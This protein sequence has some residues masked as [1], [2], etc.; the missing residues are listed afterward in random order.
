MMQRAS[1]MTQ[2]SACSFSVLRANGVL[3]RANLLKREQLKKNP[4]I[5]LLPSN[6]RLAQANLLIFKAALIGCESRYFL[7]PRKAKP[8]ASRK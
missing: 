5:R 2:P 6:R 1:T 4:A 7:D 3:A 8:A